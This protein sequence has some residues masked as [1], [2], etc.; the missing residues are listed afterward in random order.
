MP[1]SP[2]GNILSLWS[3]LGLHRSIALSATVF[4]VPVALLIPEFPDLP[5]SSPNQH[6][7]FFIA[8][9]YFLVPTSLLVSFLLLWLKKKNDQGM[10]RKDFIWAYDSR[11]L[12]SIMVGILS[13]WHEA[14]SVSWSE[15]DYK[16]SKPALGDI[17]SA[18]RPHLL[19]LPIQ[20]CLDSCVWMP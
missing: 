2:V 20:H 16:H 10:Y 9:P 4:Q 8:T 13:L 14:D 5:Y 17:L 19:N 3:L 12:E 6:F 18:K 11:G 15:W 7:R 1:S